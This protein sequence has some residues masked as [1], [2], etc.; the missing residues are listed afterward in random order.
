MFLFN[1]TKKIQKK[2]FTLG[3]LSLVFI[4]FTLIVTS[5]KKSTEISSEVGTEPV[6]GEKVELPTGNYIV[7]NDIKEGF[8]NIKMISGNGNV[9]VKD[10][11]ADIVAD[12]SMKGKAAKL[13]IA[14]ME[15]YE[16]HV[17][18]GAKVAFNPTPMKS[19]MITE[20]KETVLYSGFWYVGKDIAPG[21]YKVWKNMSSDSNIGIVNNK[22]KF[23]VNNKMSKDKSGLK[24]FI[25]DLE[26]G[27]II[28]IDNSNGIYFTP[29]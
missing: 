13:R 8:Y 21:K 19:K 24:E 20:K 2:L 25:I 12:E 10:G 22:D 3:T 11:N 15:G 7:G 14:V 18:N 17:S 16:V 26:D 1:G 9:V 5:C 23:K 29:Q 4:T 28:K 6:I 27:D